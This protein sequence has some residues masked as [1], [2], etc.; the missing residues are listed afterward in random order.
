MAQGRFYDRFSPLVRRVLIAMGAGRRRRAP[1]VTEHA[2]P[3]GLGLRVA[4]VSDIHSDAA[5]MPAA[6]VRAIVDQVNGI[7]DIDAVLL[8]GD[9]VG[10]SV[11]TIDWCAVEL[12]RLDAPAFAV[13]GNHDVH[14]GPAR[15][16]DALRASGIT[17]LVDEAVQFRD[18]VWIAGLDSCFVRDPDVDGALADIPSEATCIVMGHEPALALR[19][20][21]ALHI[22]GHTHHG[23]IR[24]P[25]LPWRYLPPHSEPYPEGL[26]EVAT[27]GGTRWVYTS[28]GVGSTTVPF[29]IGCPAAINVLEL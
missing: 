1:I 19:H 17:T 26:Y 3:L 15:V 12:A 8:P 5:F 2:I 9:F 7:P 22:A 28:A 13:L 18:G 4:V 14:Q 6:A 10:Q 27:R 21:Q 16:V 11:T 25:L 23:Q 24:L 20:E 29:R